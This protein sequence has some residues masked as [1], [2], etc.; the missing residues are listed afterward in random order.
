MKVNNKIESPKKFDVVEL[1]NFLANELNI[2]ENAELTIAYNPELLKKISGEVE[3]QALLQNPT[4]NVYY[5]F[6]DNIKCGLNSVLC[7]EM[8][9][10]HQCDRG[11]LKLSN[12]HKSITWKGEVFDNSKEYRKREWEDEAFDM[13]D[14]LW[15]KFKK[16]E[17]CI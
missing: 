14:K 15:K 4:K 11:D 12:D 2:S 8:V 7:H 1:I 16:H 6:V 10:L 3:Y 17:S 13:Q 5:L 9:H